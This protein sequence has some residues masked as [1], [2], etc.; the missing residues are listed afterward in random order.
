MTEDTDEQ[1][2]KETYEARFGT[3]PSIEPSTPVQLESL[4]GVVVSKHLEALQT[5]YYGD[6]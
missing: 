6:F 5:P 4:T 2:V 1:P 3:V